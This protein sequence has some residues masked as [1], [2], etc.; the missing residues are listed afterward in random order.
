ML[1]FRGLFEG[2]LADFYGFFLFACGH[3]GS[4]G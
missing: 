2:L 1:V 4:P 3:G